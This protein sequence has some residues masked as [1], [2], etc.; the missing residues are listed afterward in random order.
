MIW[1]NE[2]SK[3]VDSTVAV[4]CNQCSRETQHSIIAAVDCKWDREEYDYHSWGTAQII[5]CGGCGTIGF[6]DVWQSSEDP[7]P[8]ET[9]YPERT[10][11]SKSLADDLYLR[12]AL[13]DVPAII[14]VVYRETLSA[15]QHDLP[16]LAGLGIRTVIEATCKHLKAKKR[17]LRDMIDELASMSLLTPAGAKIL[18]G[19]RLLGNDAAHKMRAPSKRQ[20]TAALRVI[21]HLLLGVYV[22]PKEA[23]VLPK[24]RKKKSKKAGKGSGPVG[25][26]S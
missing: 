8:H 17:D 24:P 7:E 20:I 12:D 15:A 21:E 3:T 1:R 5:Q 18:H 14:Q 16:T 9:L 23:K 25:T 4:L 13:Y 11:K 10:A 19:I 6:R 26:G 22:L 2:P